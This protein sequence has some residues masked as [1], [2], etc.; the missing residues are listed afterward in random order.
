MSRPYALHI[1]VA[2]PAPAP[3][4]KKTVTA[5]KKKAKQT[6]V[7]KDEKSNEWK[8]ILLDFH[9]NKKGLSQNV[10][11]KIKGLKETTFLRGIGASVVLLA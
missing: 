2:A 3:I 9:N 4:R 5:P 10:Y 6:E 8:A 11:S 1:E 7:Q